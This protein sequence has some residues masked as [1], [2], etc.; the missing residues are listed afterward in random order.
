MEVSLFCTIIL[1]TDD[2]ECEI[3]KVDGANRECWLI[4]VQEIEFLSYDGF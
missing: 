3:E 1:V 4:R 2:K